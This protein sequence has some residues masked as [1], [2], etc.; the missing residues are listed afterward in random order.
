M[1]VEAFRA[2]VAAQGGSLLGPALTRYLE[3]GAQG[4]VYA[5]PAGFEA[6]ISGGGNLPLY[7]KT[8]AALAGLYEQHRPDSL[9]DIGCGNG[10]ALLPALQQSSHRPARLDLVEPSAALLEQV[11]PQVPAAVEV[12]THPSSL[13]AALADLPQGVR[14]SLAESTFALHTLPPDE[15]SEALARLRTRVG[16]L[17]IVEFD[18]PDEVPGG[19]EQ[20]ARLARTYEQGLAEYAHDAEQFDLVAQG[21]LMPVLVGQ[22]SPGAPRVTWEQSSGRWQ[23]QVSAAGFRDVQVRALYD[24]WSAPA[25]LLTGVA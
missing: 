25:F 14:W 9:V 1:T 21:F 11:L 12:H 23:E 5:T 3:S 13:Q 6:F 17:A 15:R 20:L 19:P 10:R 18:V 4:G 24:Y 8:S 7:E 22:L 2:V 16:R